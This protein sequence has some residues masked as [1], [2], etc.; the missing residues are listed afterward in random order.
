MKNLFDPNEKV[1]FPKREYEPSTGMPVATTPEQYHNDISMY[2]CAVV[3]S[4]DAYMQYY[5][6]SIT[7]QE[8]GMRKETI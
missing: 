3:R 8:N 4:E 5:M 2:G 7:K 1:L 6:K